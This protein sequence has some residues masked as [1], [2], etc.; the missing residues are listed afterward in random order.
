MIVYIIW[1]L[2]HQFSHYEFSSFALLFHDSH[3]TFLLQTIFFVFSLR[4]HSS[5]VFHTNY[6]FSL[7]EFFALIDSQLANIFDRFCHDQLLLNQ[8]ICASDD[9]SLFCEFMKNSRIRINSFYFILSNT[10]LNRFFE[11]V[12]HVVK[13]MI[14]MNR[15]RWLN[16]WRWQ[17]DQNHRR[18]IRKQLNC[19][20]RR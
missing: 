11:N 6:V 15:S 7:N 14:R 19:S 4:N 2:F 5:A 20:S 12:K 9:H 8:T 3:F 17:L 10:Q 16:C 13:I 18:I 1:Y